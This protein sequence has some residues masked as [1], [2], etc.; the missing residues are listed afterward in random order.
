MYN[1]SRN[2]AYYEERSAIDTD[3]TRA[4]MY[5]HGHPIRNSTNMSVLHFYM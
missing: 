3:R 1:I 5:I 2:P 4:A